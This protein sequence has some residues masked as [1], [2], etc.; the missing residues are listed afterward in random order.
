MARKK[1]IEQPK[2][3][4]D[5]IT[6]VLASVGIDKVAEKVSEALTGDKD[7][8]CQARA[9]FL[10]QLFPYQSN[11]ESEAYLDIDGERIRLMN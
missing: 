10:N 2:G 1:K 5:S 4:G 9:E 3:L 8:G 11:Q 6:N 7:C